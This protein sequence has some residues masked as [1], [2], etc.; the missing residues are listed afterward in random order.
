MADASMDV[1]KQ[2]DQIKAFVQQ[3]VNGIVVVAVDSSSCEPITEM[4]LA[5]KIPLAYC[6]VFPFDEENLN[7]PQGVYY[8]GSQEIQAGIIQ[9]GMIGEALNG[10]GGV[11]ILM[12]LLAH[13]ASYKRTA[14]VKQ[15]LSQKYP[16]IKILAEE[17][18][19]W[20]RDKGVDVANNWLTALGSDM[21]CIASNND[22]MALGAIRA[23]K[24]AG[25]DDV[26]VYGVD[27]TPEAM[28]SIAVGELNGTVYQDMKGQAKGA[29]DIVYKAAKG[30]MVSEQILW[31]P[32]KEVNAGNAKDFQTSY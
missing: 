8:V 17:A 13:E 18:G 21:K 16:G 12:G 1:I 27:A 28:A 25:R 4:V 10:Q 14:G 6:N 20:Q 26:I 32:F 7:I 5:A 30:E 11:A 3:K 15:V 29:M 19:D 23:L 24:A 31:I 2:Q 9:G 22:E